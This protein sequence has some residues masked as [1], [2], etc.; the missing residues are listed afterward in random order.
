[1]VF[2]SLIFCIRNYTQSQSLC[3]N[4]TMKAQ[5]IAGRQLKKLLKLNPLADRLRAMYRKLKHAYYIAIT[6][7][8]KVSALAIKEQIRIIQ[9]KRYALDLKQKNILNDS[10]S[11]IKKVFFKFKRKLA[12]FKSPKIRMLHPLPF[13]LAIKARPTKDIAPSYYVKSHFSKR[14]KISINW[15][16]FL[17]HFLP[18]WLDISFFNKL[19]S[20]YSCSSTLYKKKNTWMI[21]LSS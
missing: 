6:M 12:K 4:Y 17:Y 19:L 16:M 18:H 15:T 8:N 21:G 2:I 10:L 11:Q 3:I 14:Q 1:M 13:G 9:Q 7:G 5:K 20:A